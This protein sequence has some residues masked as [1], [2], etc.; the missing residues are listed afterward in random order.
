M[1]FFVMNKKGIIFAKQ[2]SGNSSVGRAQPC[3]GWGREFESR[4]PLNADSLRGRPE[5]RSCPGGGMVD[6]HVSG[7]CVERHAGSS[8]VLGT[9]CGNS[10]VGRAQPCQGWGREFESR[11]P[12]F[13][14]L[15]R[16]LRWWNR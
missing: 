6:A 9:K 7:A 4:F 3:Q 11:F 2:L 5:G 14:Y 13:F 8:P 15:W 12:L 16:L 1:I 10:S